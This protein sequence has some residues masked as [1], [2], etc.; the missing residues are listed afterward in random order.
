MEVMDQLVFGMTDAS[1]VGMARR[2]ASALG[3]RLGFDEQEAGKVALVVTEVGTNLVKHAR[4]GELLLC[5]AREGTAR[6]VGVLALDRGPGIANLAECLRDGYSTAGSPGM[7][8]GAIRR[9]SATFDAYS[10]DSGTVMV[11]LLWP[12]PPPPR[13]GID[14]EGVCV[15]KPGED[16][17][18]DAWAFVHEPRRSLVMVADGVGHGPEAAAAAAEACRVFEAAAPGS[19]VLDLLAR[20]HDALRPT[21][22]A[23]A[24][25]AELDAG[26]RI[27][28]FAGIGNIAGTIVFD[29]RTRSMVSQHGV[30]GHAVRKL[31][32]FSYAWPPGATIVL[33]SDGL[34]TRWT[35]D[36]YPG[37]VRRHPLLAAAVLYRDFRRG[38]DD[39]TVVVVREAA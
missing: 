8:L 33:H 2:A 29:G 32:D 35:F 11:S 7:G 21:R 28:R 31:Q 38:N 36:G 39:A 25:V 3:R 20:L 24:A 22:G 6:G 27:V 9:L 15:A 18:G 16:R 37:L 19:T 12:G 5:V 4:D 17:C 14:V 30:L 34:G 10:A 1:Q 26:G 13:D 23:A